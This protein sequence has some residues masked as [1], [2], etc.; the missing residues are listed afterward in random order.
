VNAL[1]VEDRIDLG[2]G[3]RHI[4]RVEVKSK[5]AGGDREPE[6]FEVPVD[7]LVAATA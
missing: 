5:K 2:A 6:Q 7:A 3:G 4:V 1:V